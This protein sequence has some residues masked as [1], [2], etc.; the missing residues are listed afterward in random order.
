MGYRHDVLY[1]TEGNG[2]I[3][4]IVETLSILVGSIILLGLFVPIAY[5]GVRTKS[6]SKESR[7]SV[8]NDKWQKL[9]VSAR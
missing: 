8:L 6:T 4:N 7:I 5:E 2:S 3:M 9:T 1:G